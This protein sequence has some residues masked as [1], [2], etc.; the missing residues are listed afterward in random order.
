[1]GSR[2]PWVVQSLSV[3]PT[4]TNTAP[5]TCVPAPVYAGLQLQD[6]GGNPVVGAVVQMFETPTSGPPLREIGEAFTDAN[7]NF[8]M[9]LVP[10][11]QGQTTC[12]CPVQ[13]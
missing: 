13:P 6:P 1:M 10:L 3:G 8:D 12:T 5:P 4:P 9:Y 2:L 11:G 7:G